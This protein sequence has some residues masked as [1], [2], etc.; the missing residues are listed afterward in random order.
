MCK[1]VPPTEITKIKQWKLIP[2]V[3]FS[4]CQ[5]Q[6][7][8]DYPNV[9]LH[10]PVEISAPP[11]FGQWHAQKNINHSLVGVIEFTES[12]SGS[13]KVNLWQ[14]ENSFKYDFGYKRFFFQ[15]L[16][17]RN[18]L[19]T[20]VWSQSKFQWWWISNHVRYGNH[21]KMQSFHYFLWNLQFLERLLETSRTDTL[22]SQ[23]IFK[24]A[25]IS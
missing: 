2:S 6:C 3:N 21:V 18:S 9:E 11:A 25:N 22:C 12:W 16:K 15:L 24:C 20:L 23:R 13:K 5:A 7:N 1:S 10:W 4:Q 19:V 8:S 17:Q 14:I